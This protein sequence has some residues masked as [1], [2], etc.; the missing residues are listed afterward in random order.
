MLH[1]WTLED[2]LEGGRYLAVTAKVQ[3]PGLYLLSNASGT[4]CWFELEDGRAFTYRQCDFE[5]TLE[6]LNSEKINARQA[7]ALREIVAQRLATKE[8]RALLTRYDENLELT[9][10]GRNARRSMLRLRAFKLSRS[11]RQ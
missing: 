6:L 11:A 3:R 4:E 7:A 5:Y 8:Q 10:I 1:D 2:C 9:I